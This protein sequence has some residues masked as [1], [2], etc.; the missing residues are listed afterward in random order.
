LGVEAVD[1][2]LDGEQESPELK[3]VATLPAIAAITNRA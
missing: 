3:N 2:D 1:G